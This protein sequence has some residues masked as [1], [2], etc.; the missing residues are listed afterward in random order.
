MFTHLCFYQV[1]HPPKAVSLEKSLT[2]IITWQKC[3]LL[4]APGRSLCSLHAPLRA[5][6]LGKNAGRLN[7]IA[8]RVWPRQLQYLVCSQESF[9]VGVGCGYKTNLCPSF[10]NA[11]SLLIGDKDAT[12]NSV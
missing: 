9:L 11:A 1:A 5:A 6:Q 2:E 8:P 12:I 10:D 4:R 3:L 7:R